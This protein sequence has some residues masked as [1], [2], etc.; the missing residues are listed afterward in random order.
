MTILKAA[1]SPEP[2]SESYVFEQPK[3]DESQESSSIPLGAKTTVRTALTQDKSLAKEAHFLDQITALEKE[4]ADK[5]KAIEDA[6]KAAYDEGIKVGEK[7]ATTKA[8]EAL[9]LLK[10]SLKKGAKTLEESLG[11]QVDLGV[12]LARTI[13]S[14]VLGDAYLLPSH[15]TS[16]AQHWKQTLCSGSIVRVRVCADDFA[17]QAALDA[18]HETLPSVEIVPQVDLKPGACFFDLKLGTLDASI[19]S[20]LAKA[21]TLLDQSPQA[22]EVH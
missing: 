4:L 19:D 8:D 9:E 18:L 16:T 22:A 10:A 2:P 3:P 15:V 7:S 12:D 6:K 11:D 14:H 17:D 13:L 1:N 20:Q 5:E 21:D